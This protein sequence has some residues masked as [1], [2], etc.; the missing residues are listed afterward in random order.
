MILLFIPARL[1][2]AAVLRPIAFAGVALALAGSAEAHDFSSDIICRVIES[3]GQ[4][5]A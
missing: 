2:G 5:S 1:E 4:R 3:D